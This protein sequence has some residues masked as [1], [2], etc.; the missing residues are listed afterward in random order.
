[1]WSNRTPWSKIGAMA[2]PPNLVSIG[3]E[4]RDVESLIRSLKAQNVQV[5][6]DVRLNPIS[7]KRG[8]SKTALRSALDA[9]GIGYL[10]LRELGNP[11]DNRD[12]YRRGAED[13]LRRF[14]HVLESAEGA[15]AL[16]H[17]SELLD[18]GAVALLCFERDHAQCHRHQV[19]EAVLE[20]RSVALVSV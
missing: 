11:K 8:F 14:E 2:F 19:A 12:A 18:G 5:L 20:Q 3:Y 9:A 10:H 16:R 17:V 1:M 13:A 6:V 15:Q 7:R 4:G